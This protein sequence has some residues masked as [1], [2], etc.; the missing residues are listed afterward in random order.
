MP[1]AKRQQK[2]KLILQLPLGGYEIPVYSVKGLTAKHNV[3]GRFLLKERQ[4]EID[5]ALD[6]DEWWETLIHESVHACEEIYGFSLSE[7]TVERLGFG[8]WSMLR[9]FLTE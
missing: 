1:Q 7:K 2:R 6:E 9:G 4:I 3:A 8:L 5:S